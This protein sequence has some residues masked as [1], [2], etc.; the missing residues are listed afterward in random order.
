M[1]LEAVEGGDAPQ[2]WNAALD[3]LRQSAELGLILAQA[4]LA[5]LAATASRRRRHVYR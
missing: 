2:D 5:G 4:S 1:A 3:H